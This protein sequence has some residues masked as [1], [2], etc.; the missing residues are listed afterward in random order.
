MK[1]AAAIIHGVGKQ[2]PDF[3]D[4]MIESLI[5]EF[6]SEAGITRAMARQELIIEPVYWAPVM[7]RPEDDLWKRL[8][9]QHDLDF[10]ALRQIMID[11]AGDGLAYQPARKEQVV[12]DQVHAVVANSLTKLSQSAGPQ[13]P[14]CVI[15]HSLG[16][17]IASNFFYDLQ[18]GKSAAQTPLEQGKTLT[19][20]YTMGSPIAIWSLR[21]RASATSVEFGT[22]IDVPARELPGYYPSLQG[23]WLNFFDEDDVIGY[24]L[25][26]LNNEYEKRV[27][28]V[29]VNVGNLLSSWNPASH[30]G[31]WDDDDIIEPIA[32][33]LARTWRAVNA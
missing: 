21:Y 14:L 1:I 3:A 32:K 9:S 5:N 22:P 26:V 16:T 19:L 33:S 24:P 10:L 17:V 8:K 29:P 25:Q 15:S 12:Y 4:G 7:Q 30:L 18:S 23:E 20:F 6:A 11:L 31:Y 27:K 13:A 28:D 2:D